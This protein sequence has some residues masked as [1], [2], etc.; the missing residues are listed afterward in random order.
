MHSTSLK[1][2]RSLR[3]N[4]DGIMIAFCHLGLALLAA[5]MSAGI[6]IAGKL[7]ATNIP[8][9]DL[10]LLRVSIASLCFLPFLRRKFFKSLTRND[11]GILV[12]AGF[13]G[14]FL[15]NVLYFQGLTTSSA[16][17]A[18]LINSLT[19]GLMLMC[20]CLYFRQLPTREQIFSFS[21]ALFGVFLITTDGN[22]NFA[23][24]F[25]NTG[26]LLMLLSVLCWVI[27]SI[28]AQQKSDA[29]PC[30]A[31][32]FGALIIGTLLLIPISLSNNSTTQTI[33]HLC[34]KEWLLILYIALI[35]TGCGYFLYGKSIEQIGPDMAAYIMYSMTPVFV[36]PLTFLFFDDPITMWEV[37]GSLCILGSLVIH[38]RAE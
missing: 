9:T 1:L 5:L 32:T 16:L 17:H 25:E 13:F 38:V 33:Q 10:T 6:A 11:V 26:N 28:A 24:L 19:P 34:C 4:G 2:R 21:L 12:L 18:A 20:T 29:L 22:F 7:L 15:S 35:G 37:A 23:A 31:F 27:Y 30:T 8:P 14:I 36:L 3:V